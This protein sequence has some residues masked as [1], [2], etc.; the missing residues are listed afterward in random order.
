MAQFRDELD[1]MHKNKIKE[2]KQR[3]HEIIERCKIKEREVE[4]VA[5]EHRQNVLKDLE[6]LRFK[7]QDGKK[8][9]EMELL[10]VKN[11]RE[12][13]QQKE[14]EFDLK[15]KDLNL[16]KIALE[17]KTQSEIEEYRRKFEGERDD[18]KR[19]LHIRKMQLEEDEHRF[20]MNKDK[21]LITEKDKR[22]LEKENVE[23]KEKLEK[24]TDDHDTMTK[25]YIDI[26]DQLKVLSNN[27]LRDNDIIHSKT[28]QAETYENEARTLRELL[29]AQKDQMRKGKETTDEIIGNLRQQLK[30]Q[31]ELNFNIK[32]QLIGESERQA[33]TFK[34]AN[35]AEKEKLR[36]EI[37]HLARKVECEQHLTKELTIVNDKLLQDQ[38]GIGGQAVGEGF[39]TGGNA[40]F[41][42]RQP[43]FLTA[44]GIPLINTFG[45]GNLGQEY[46][47]RQRAWESL[48]EENRNVKRDINKI[49]LV[50][51]SEQ[52]V[53][54]YY[55]IER[56]EVPLEVEDEVTP[57]VQSP[58]KFDSYFPDE[59]NNSPL[60]VQR[61]GHNSSRDDAEY[62]E[63]QLEKADQERKR[64]EEKQQKD[65]MERNRKSREEQA[66]RDKAERE[67]KARKDRE[68]KARRDREA[69]QRKDKA[70]QDRREREERQRKEKADR[71]KKEKDRQARIA[72]E[73]EQERLRLEREKKEKE[74]IGGKKLSSDIKNPFAKKGGSVAKK[75]EPVS[76]HTGFGYFDK[77][78]E[79]KSKGFD[80]FNKPEEPKSKGFDYF[81]K[82]E[83]P[84]SKGFDYFDKPE[85]PKSK[86][87]DYFD[88]PE[89]PKSKGF[90]YFDK[91]EEK[92]SKGFSYFDKPKEEEKKE[93][94]KK[95]TGFSY[96][97]KPEDKKPNRQGSSSSNNNYGLFENKQSLP[98]DDFDEVV[99]N[100]EGS[101]EIEDS[102]GSED[103]NF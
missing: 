60:R 48:N 40:G 18:E 78:E 58:N 83:E 35:K 55:D 63:K 101:D 43:D 39:S 81:D 2:L 45:D 59:K 10:V 1:T 13:L 32:E 14:K 71:E 100:I 37:D 5:F 17:K 49:G 62:L 66:K 21:Y 92:K 30:E 103:F 19:D 74:P 24:I 65:R 16:L 44:N 25:D 80:Y 84:K 3:E 77:P 46:L 54:P 95:N 67:E 90:D 52:F 47:E 89:E 70:D 7:E 72:K 85:E 9:I 28:A 93:S 97:D 86:G 15:L 73:K 57:R 29:E 33:Q 102:Y 68:D 82:P 64:A 69:K 61:L 42:A 20:A 96:F 11:E 34:L 53:K 4:A 56:D 8:T 22:Q 87:F 79:P 75:P 12:N 27:G 51:I 23:L 98:K 6:T 76:K 50:P 41:G 31:K 91:P 38:W 94:E 99:E 88:K 36:N 26:K